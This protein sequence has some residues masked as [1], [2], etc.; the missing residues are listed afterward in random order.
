MDYLSKAAGRTHG[1]L[2]MAWY[3][4]Y[5]TSS[6]GI[7]EYLAHSTKGVIFEQGRQPWLFWKS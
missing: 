7:H 2:V 6:R 3:V 5:Q 1:L 4:K